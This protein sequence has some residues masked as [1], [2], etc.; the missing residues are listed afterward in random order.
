MPSYRAK[1]ETVLRREIIVE[2]PNADAARL[3]AE[4]YAD[5]DFAKIH[6]YD[7]TVDAVQLTE[8]TEPV[9][10]RLV[11]KYDLKNAELADFM[12]Y[13]SGDLGI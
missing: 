3:V 6:V 1:I 9:N 13:R 7:E 8:I 12:E 4:Y 5:T 2:A 11:R 10:K